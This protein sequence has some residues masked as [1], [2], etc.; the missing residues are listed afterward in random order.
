M[1][2]RIRGALIGLCLGLFFSAPALLA[3]ERI[4][5]F[6][7]PTGRAG[8]G[9]SFQNV[10]FDVA[11]AGLSHDEIIVSPN[12]PIHFLF[13]AE[14]Q[15]IGLT[16]RFKVPLSD[17]EV[18]ERGRTQFVD[19]QFQYHR[20]Q[21]EVDLI[22]QLHQGMYVENTESFTEPFSSSKLPDFLL[23]TVAANFFY[24]ANPNYSLAAAYRLNARHRRSGASL[25]WLGGLS[26]IWMEAPE[27]PARGMAAA[28]GTE[29]HEDVYF[30]ARSVNGGAGGTA[31]VQFGPWFFSPLF[32]IAVGPQLID[33]AVVGD[34]GRR[35]TLAPL[36]FGRLS[37]GY[38][39]DEFFAAFVGSADWR[40]VQVPRISATQGTYL[41]ELVVG[42][43]F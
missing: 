36:I 1:S 12:S 39:A 26:G 30:V 33:Y 10:A 13:G 14:W 25:V 29:A 17:T 27:G 43:R 7:N 42:K 28:E 34:S 41:I 19:F 11:D 22:Y 32:G 16:A 9:F 31:T 6:E 3:E 2:S 40:G 4:L 18:E 8:L 15:N 23:Q 37:F 20:D 5:R 38:N 35:W 21:L 24:A